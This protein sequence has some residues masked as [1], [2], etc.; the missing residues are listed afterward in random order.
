MKKIYLYFGLALSMLAVSCS[1]GPKEEPVAPDTSETSVQLTL[2]IV[3]EGVVWSDGAEVSVNGTEVAISDG[4]GTASALAVIEKELPTP[5]WVVSPVSAYS[6]GNIITV[7][8]TQNYVENGYDADAYILVGYAEA[9]DATEETPALLSV[10]AGEPAEVKT[11][12]VNLNGTCGIVSVPMVVEAGAAASIK[13]VILGTDNT[14]LALAGSFKVSTED[15]T[16]APQK[17]VNSITV[18]CGETGVAL[19]QSTPVVFN[20]VVP[21][22]VYEG[23]LTVTASDAEGHNYVQG[24]T[25]PLIVEATQTVAL[26][27][28]VFE[29]IE[30]G[31][32]TLNVTIAGGIATWAAGDKI[33]VNNELSPEVAASA[34]GQTAASFDFQAIAYPYSVF[35]PASLYTSSGRLRFYNTQKL[36]PDGYDKEASVMIGYATGTDVVLENVCGLVT[37]P[38]LNKYEGETISI[39]SLC[40]RSANGEPL[41]GKYMV[42]YRNKTLTSTE[43]SDYIWVVPEKNET[44]EVVNPLLIAPEETKDIQ[45]VVPAGAFAKGLLVDL[46]TS[47]GVRENIAC[48]ATGVEVTRGQE[49]KLPEV[50]KYEDIP[51]TPIMTA[52]ELLEFAK[53]VNNGRYKKFISH[54]AATEGQVILGADIDMS[55]INWVS[56]NGVDGAG[57]DGIFN[58]QGHK[59]TNW[60]SYGKSLFGVLAKGG[61]VKNLTIDASCQLTYPNVN[62]IGDVTNFGF[63][64]ANNNGGTIDTVTNNADITLTVEGEMGY[65][66]RAGSI[67]GQSNVGSRLLNLT[68][69]GNITFNLGGVKAAADSSSTTQ[70]WGGVSGAIT[71]D[72]TS[73]TDDAARSIIDNCH[74][75]GNLTFNI[76]GESKHGYYIGGVTGTCNSCSEMYNSSNK[77]NVTLNL[78]GEDSSGNSHTSQISMGGCASYSSGPVQNVTNSGKVTLYAKGCIR[79]TAIGGITGYQNG[80]VSD[81]VN[82]GAIDVQYERVYGVTTIGGI[83]GSKST[84]QASTTVAGISALCYSSDNYAATFNNCVNNGAIKVI[85]RDITDRKT[86]GRF[87]VAGVVAAPW[88]DITACKNYGSIDVSASNPSDTADGSTNV[89]TYIGGIAASD[90]YAKSQSSTNII[91]CT[92]EGNIKANLAAYKSNSA[93]GGIIGWPGK[94]SSCTSVTSGCVNKGNI[95]VLGGTK[96]RMGGIQGGSGR[97]ENCINYGAVSAV[98]ETL[99]KACC[100]GGVAGFHSYAQYQMLNCE[101]YGTVSSNAKLTSGGGIAGLIGN[102]GNV[103]NSLTLGCKV[104]CSVIAVEGCEAA[105]LVARFNGSGSVISFGSEDEPIYVKGMLTK[106]GVS[107]AISSQDAITVETMFGTDANAVSEK[108]NDLSCV[109]YWK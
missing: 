85:E 91:D 21:A 22:G 46:Y 16:Y 52:E 20:F 73:L 67:V 6:A 5:L 49:S 23:G 83:D 12:T 3:D 53:A 96:V 36:V 80:P 29:I 11:A 79:T 39:D 2:N 94:E 4:A 69:T 64:V 32:A 87:S 45:V 82:D 78:N 65:Q 93:I 30:K 88:G 9:Y 70:Y 54:E 109:Y 38:I 84:S 77:G 27:T 31:P 66:L 95:E 57:F 92:N 61:V 14:D 42:N 24:Y 102:F 63:V 41:A 56:A 75:T 68:N 33:V 98:S 71:S 107:T 10:A 59:I 8:D 90:Y 100:L 43:P 37:I 72:D 60:T 51:I 99:N 48:F 103:G 25:E 89:L 97:L 50:V 104:N 40:V 1:N 28:V 81:V 18:D 58:G 105:M 55:G 86:T 47:V 106:G 15:G 19:G 34:V 76:N 13:S 101:N 17:T 7:P 62:E 44:G 74:N 35:Y 26:E 108:H